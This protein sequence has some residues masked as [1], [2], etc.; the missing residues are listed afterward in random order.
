ML[1]SFIDDFRHRGAYCRA[2]YGNRKCERISKREFV[3]YYMG[4]ST[5]ID[6][7]VQFDYMMRHNWKI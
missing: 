1:K 6:K 4:Y 5:I 2:M 7:D 3:D